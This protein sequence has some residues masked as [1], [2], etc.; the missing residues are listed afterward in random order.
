MD[1]ERTAL[2]RLVA[3]RQATRDRFK[4][5][6]AELRRKERDVIGDIDDQLGEW[7]MLPWDVD[8]YS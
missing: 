1:V 7:M 8:H 6:S 3:E 4:R 2:G 5:L